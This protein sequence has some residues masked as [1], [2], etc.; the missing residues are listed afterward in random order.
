MHRFLGVDAVVFVEGGA[1]TY[2]LQEVEKGSYNSQA[3]DLKYWQIIFTS[4]ASRGKFHFR[5]VGSKTTIMEIAALIASGQVHHIFAAMDRDFDNLVGAIP[6]VA[7]VFYTLG[8]SWENDV[9]TSAVVFATFR[10][11]NTAPGSEDAAKKEIEEAFL[12]FSKRVR[13]GVCVDAILAKNNLEPLAREKFVKVVRPV[14]GGPPALAATA[15]KDLIRK[16]RLNTRPAR[17]FGGGIKVD[18]LGDCQ[19]HLL[20]N[21]GYHLLV[22]VLS[23]YCKIKTTPRDLLVPAAIDAFS[24]VIQINSAL[25]MHYSGLFSAI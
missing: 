5:A 19:G 9:W 21:F 22:Y 25:K 8:Y 13:R 1:S 3:D 14:K 16:H 2:T 23:K 20:E 18:V 11:F 17:V 24:Y 7:G 15:I 10:K 6:K 4:F 12:M